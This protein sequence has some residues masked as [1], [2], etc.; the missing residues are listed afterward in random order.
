MESPMRCACSASCVTHST[1][2]PA[3]RTASSTRRFDRSSRAL[4]G[5]SSKRTRGL[6]ASPMASIARWDSPPDSLPHGLSRYSLAGHSPNSSSRGSSPSGARPALD[7]NR[8]TLATRSRGHPSS[9]DFDWWTYRT[10]RRQS[11]ARMSAAR[12]PR[13]DALPPRHGCRSDSRRRTVDLPT[14]LGPM[15]TAISP[16]WSSKLTATRLLPPIRPSMPTSRSTSSA[17]A[18]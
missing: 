8:W 16:G 5:S 7:L 14:P 2:Q 10:S 4:V 12:A 1:A 11:W 15:T 3:F 18:A 6:A 13:S 9:A 17:G